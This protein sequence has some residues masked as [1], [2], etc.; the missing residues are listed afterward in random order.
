MGKERGERAAARELEEPVYFRGSPV[1]DVS[2]DEQGSRVGGSASERTASPF[3]ARVLRRGA[4]TGVGNGERAEG[5]PAGPPAKRRRAEDGAA[6]VPAS[7]ASE[8]ACA[9][10]GSLLPSLEAQQ[11]PAPFPGAL[12]AFLA[13]LAARRSAAP[14]MFGCYV[15]REWRKLSSGPGAQ[16]PGGYPGFSSLLAASLRLFPDRIAPVAVSRGRIH[17]ALYPPDAP[18]GPGARRLPPPSSEAE[19]RGYAEAVLRELRADLGDDSPVP[20]AAFEEAWAAVMGGTSFLDDWAR[21]SVPPP[22][23]PPRGAADVYPDLFTPAPPDRGAPSS[24]APLASEPSAS[25]PAPRKRS[26]S[27]SPPRR[28]RSRTPPSSRARRSPGRWRSSPSPSPSSRRLSSPARRPDALPYIT[29]LSREVHACLAAA[30]L[31]LE[32]D[33][34]TVAELEEEW[35]RRGESARV[36]LPLAL[37]VGGLVRKRSS[38]GER[39]NAASRLVEGASYSAGVRKIGHEHASKDSKEKERQYPCFVLERGVRPQDKEALRGLAKEAEEGYRA[40]SALA[41]CALCGPSAAFA[42]PVAERAKAELAARCGGEKPEPWSALARRAADSASRRKGP[43]ELDELASSMPATVREALEQ[44]CPA[45]GRASEPAA[46]A[47]RP[48]PGPAPVHPLARLQRTLLVAL[49]HFAARLDLTAKGVDSTSLGARWA[50]EGKPGEKSWRTAF[51]AAMLQA[52]EEEGEVLPAGPFPGHSAKIGEAVRWLL[53]PLGIVAKDWCIPKSVML[54][55]EAPR[56]YTIQEHVEKLL[57]R[58]GPLPLPC[59]SFEPGPV[60]CGGGKWGTRDPMPMPIPPAPAAPPT[61]AADT[62][63]PKRG[64]G[65]LGAAPEAA[66]AAPAPERAS[67]GGPRL[68]GYGLLGSSPSPPTAGAAGPERGRTPSLGGGNPAPR[69]APDPRDRWDPTS[70]PARPRLGPAPTPEPTPA[71][72][73]PPPV[74]LTP[75]PSHRPRPRPPTP[76]P[77]PF[78]PRPVPQAIAV[79]ARVSAGVPRPNSQERDLRGGRARAGTP[80]E[81][82]VTPGPTPPRVLLALIPS[83]RR[84]GRPSPAAPSTPGPAPGPAPA[85]SPPPPPAPTARAFPCGPR[86]SGERALLQP[87]RRSVE[88]RRL[89]A[90]A[91]APPAPSLAA[92][93]SPPRLSDAPFGPGPAR[94]F[95]EEQSPSLSGAARPPNPSPAVPAAASSEEAGALALRRE[96]R[97][98]LLAAARQKAAEARRAGLGPPKLTDVAEAWSVI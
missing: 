59:K 77:P 18:P 75:P 35:R 82:D 64:A 34:L 96:L 88:L 92:P 31:R 62:A 86:A 6:D 16:F 40:G 37:T 53:S 19:L 44:L 36:P 80:R 84:P 67:R 27:R 38:E 30:S 89:R 49:Q 7:D 91:V 2:D 83:L 60:R 79:P 51:R 43:A 24:P 69:P 56:G 73:P 29:L 26:R 21:V 47:A 33:W 3:G 66:P 42:A 17:V 13:D 98:Y 74:P 50:E 45:F 5:A 87:P 78:G 48:E 76:P 57:G 46:A 93:P 54:R 20:P 95:L 94:P 55:F 97:A 1:I 58:R 25:P 71:S 90:A 65:L 39:A 8:R 85:A 22:H 9:L 28:S 10:L 63:A 11:A 52:P 81:G 4:H 41:A 61:P 14:P 72:P 23:V 70:L 15:L 32:R 12:G 68:G